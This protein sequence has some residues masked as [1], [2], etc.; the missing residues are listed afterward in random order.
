MCQTI[1][2][3][4]ICEVGM[5]GL[6][7]KMIHTAVHRNPQATVG[8]NA[9]IGGTEVRKAGHPILCLFE[10]VSC[11][12]RSVPQE[13]STGVSYL[14]SKRGRLWLR[15]YRNQSLTPFC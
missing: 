8:T 14:C 12:T 13:S 9:S 2:A 7:Q 3:P 10:F 6:G 1:I 11:G 4:L 5:R 15:S